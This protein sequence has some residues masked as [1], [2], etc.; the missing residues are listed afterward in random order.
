VK[1]EIVSG[2]VNNIWKVCFIV[3]KRKISH[4]K[5]NFLDNEQ[6]KKLAVMVLREGALKNVKQEYKELWGFISKYYPDDYY[7]T[8][9][10]EM[11]KVV[12]RELIILVEKFRI[13]PQNPQQGVETG[14][15]FEQRI[16]QQNAN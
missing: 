12:Y 8:V 6:M 2:L 11:Y 4:L 10:D 1:R 5:S 3:R 14:S 9:S 16:L 13:N 15:S 7:Q